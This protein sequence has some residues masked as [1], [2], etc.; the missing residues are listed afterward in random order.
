MVTCLIRTK[1]IHIIFIALLTVNF[2][3]VF[4]EYAP[5]MEGWGIYEL[6]LDSNEVSLLYSTPKR[7]TVLRLNDAGDRF[8]FTLR[9]EG[10]DD[11]SDEICT[12]NLEGEEFSQLTDNDYL[13]TYPC[14]SPD[15]E[16]IIF[17]SWNSTMLSIH[18]INQDG[19]GEQTLYI[20]EFHSADPHWVGD[21]IVFTCNHS[22]WIMND[23][24]TGAIPLTFP[25]HAGV[26]SDAPLPY[27]DYDPRLSPD[28]G[29]I[30][31]ERMV[32]A[33][34]IHGGYDL[35]IMNSDGSNITA[36][37]E[38]AWTQGMASWSHS[39]D[40]LAYIVA[41]IG[42]EGKYD[43][44]TIKLDG[45]D[46][47]SLTS[48]L[49]PAFLAHD[50]IYSPDDSKIYFVGEWYGWERLDSTITCYLDKTEAALREIIHIEGYISPP[51]N[52]AQVILNITKPTG[53]L[54]VQKVTTDEDG[55][56]S[57]EFEGIPNGDWEII[58]YW[59][60]DVGHYASESE[61]RTV[62][63]KDEDP[64]EGIPGFQAEF[65][66][67]GVSIAAYYLNRKQRQ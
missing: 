12:V 26:W 41:G 57:S 53:M 44:Y 65:I 45:P 60:G 13:D 9:M 56:Y 61:T 16:R 32:D 37:T 5:Y 67:A 23:D 8:T 28:S 14:W 39:G 22:I 7:I 3:P 47:K 18:V 43:I 52:D 63:V 62:T 1:Y 31:F 21:K 33:S 24:G 42:E 29:K 25:P 27:G 4:A 35:Y 10:E 11:S 38:T 50:P 46:M 64:A 2:V 51:V 58:A 40:K 6:D 66:I 49:P 19:T 36:I 48:D 20:E 30:V 17:L 55:A 15:G 59:D 34:N 54:S